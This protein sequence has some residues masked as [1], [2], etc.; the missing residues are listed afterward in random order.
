M[1]GSGAQLRSGLASTYVWLT[2]KLKCGKKAAL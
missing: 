2:E 1:V